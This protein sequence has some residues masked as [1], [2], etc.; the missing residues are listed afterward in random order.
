M[1]GEGRGGPGRRQLSGQSQGHIAAPQLLPDK[2]FS[3]REILDRPEDSGEIFVGKLGR[4]IPVFFLGCD[5]DFWKRMKR[6][7]SDDGYSCERLINYD[8]FSRYLNRTGEKGVIVLG[9]DFG[10]GAVKPNEQVEA[11][12]IIK[13]LDPDARVVFVSFESRQNSAEIIRAGAEAIVSRDEVRPKS[14][15]EN[16]ESIIRVYA[17]NGQEHPPPIICEIVDGKAR[18]V[19]AARVAKVLETMDDFSSRFDQH[20]RLNRHYTVML[21]ILTNYP[22][23]FGSHIL[24]VGCGTGHPMRR[25]IRDMMIPEMDAPAPVRGYTRILSVDSSFTM[26]DIAKAGYTHLAQQKYLWGKLDMEFLK[27]DFLQL[28][29]ESLAQSGFGGIDTIL[30]SYFIHWANDKAGSVRRMADLLDAGGKLITVEEWPPVVTPGP[31]MTMELADKIRRNILPIDRKEYY[32]LLR[33]NGFAE[34]D[35]C[36]QVLRIDDH[37]KMYGNVFVK[38]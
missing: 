23:H 10:F 1:R 33:Q 6:R 25:L 27:S 24:D 12:R 21:D 34:E 4:E 7:L 30:V 17:E 36:V 14:L 5:E 26:L 31:Y 35:G 9:N 38:V 11:L 3:G 2:A 16:I 13:Q 19:D 8:S 18:E 20:Q 32:R 22:H 28:T 29:G 15:A 37:H